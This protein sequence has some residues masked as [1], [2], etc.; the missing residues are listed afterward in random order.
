MDAARNAASQASSDAESLRS[1]KGEL[2]EKQGIGY[3]P[4][5]VY[6]PLA[7]RCIETKVDKYTYRVCPFKEAEQVEGEHGHTS[8]GRWGGFDEDMEHMKFKDGDHCWQGPQRSIT[9]R[10]RCGA[11]EVLTR[12]AEPSRCVYSAELSTPAAC[13]QAY[14]DELRAALAAKQARLDSVKDEL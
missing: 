9:V 8:L 3:G 10:V 7:D 5:D 14:V 11:T 1:E 12:I 6:A 13:S 4:D 2:Q